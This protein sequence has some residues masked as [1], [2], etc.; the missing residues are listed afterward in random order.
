ML[1]TERL[2]GCEVGLELFWRSEVMKNEN[3]T[4]MERFKSAVASGDWEAIPALM[5]ADFALVEPKALP[6][7]GTYKGAD[8]FK[9]C[10]QKIRATTATDALEHRRT[11]LTDDP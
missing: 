6:Y 10:L 3:L 9:S 11:Y 7:G 4:V 5:D 2:A 8:G 1:C